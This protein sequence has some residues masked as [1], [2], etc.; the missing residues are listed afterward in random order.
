[1]RYFIA[2]DFKARSIEGGTKTRRDGRASERAALC[3]FVRLG[4]R[5]QVFPTGKRLLQFAKRD[6][7]V[8]SGS[9]M[10]AAVDFLQRE[11]CNEGRGLHLKAV[12]LSSVLARGHA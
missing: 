2:S 9:A 7:F 4:G 5:T 1:M 12:L 11:D 6:F 3:G 8:V 10:H